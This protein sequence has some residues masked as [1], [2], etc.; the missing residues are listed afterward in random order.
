[1]FDIIAQD[2]LVIGMFDKSFHIVFI[3]YV[4]WYIHCICT[5]TSH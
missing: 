2:A 4:T 5:G 3:I 1:M